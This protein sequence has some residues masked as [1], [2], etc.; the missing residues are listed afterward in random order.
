M[1]TALSDLTVVLALPLLKV[2]AVL[3]AQVH[4]L[5]MLL[6]VFQSSGWTTWMP[7]STCMQTHHQR[8]PDGLVNLQARVA[9]TDVTR[10]LVCGGKPRR[11]A[12]LAR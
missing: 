12:R 8:D 4:S 2:K 6:Q 9:R 11:V 1:T 3:V 7:A 5:F 10:H